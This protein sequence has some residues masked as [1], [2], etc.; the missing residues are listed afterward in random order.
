MHVISSNNLLTAVQ[1]IF[2]VKEPKCHFGKKIS[3]A[4]IKNPRK[5]FLILD[6]ATL[7]TDNNEAS[8][9]RTLPIKILLED[10]RH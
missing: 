4:S 10:Y 3:I 8:T 1:G 5:L 6:H 9:Q 2:F 7:D